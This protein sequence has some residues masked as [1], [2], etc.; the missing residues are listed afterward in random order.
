MLS[1]KRVPL[2]FGD[3]RTCM[4]ICLLYRL[5]GNVCVPSS[6]LRACLRPCWQ[7]Q[8]LPYWVS[9]WVCSCCCCCY[10]YQITSAT[11]ITKIS[12]DGL[13]EKRHHTGC[14]HSCFC[15][16][17]DRVPLEMVSPCSCCYIPRPT[18]FLQ[19][20]TELVRLWLVVPCEDVEQSDCAHFFL[21]RA[22]ESSPICSV[23]SKI[24]PLTEC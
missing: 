3:T 24:D 2:T 5:V 19:L 13:C 22:Q 6:Q 12:R 23:Y 1:Y 4:D 17:N 14:C 7:A 10:Y 11:K 15:V 16:C 9:W 20:T 18:P 21:D 8:E